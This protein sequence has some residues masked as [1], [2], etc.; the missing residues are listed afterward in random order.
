MK[1]SARIVV[2]DPESSGAS[3]FHAE[4]QRNHASDGHR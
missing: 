4:H 1:A 3:A 2:Y